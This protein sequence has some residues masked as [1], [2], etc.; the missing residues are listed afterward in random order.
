M[1]VGKR[2]CRQHGND[3]L[4]DADHDGTIGAIKHHT[5]QAYL[6]PG[7]LVIAK[8]R[9]RQQPGW[10]AKDLC[11]ALGADDKSK[12]QWGA[13][14][15][16][17]PEQRHMRENMIFSKQCSHP[18]IIRLRPEHMMCS[19]LGDRVAIFEDHSTRSFVL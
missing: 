6:V 13:H 2:K 5:P 19:G 16:N 14:N 9:S 1:E 18:E 7:L 12:D 10:I 3:E 17:G 15:E 8:M 4:A 11:L